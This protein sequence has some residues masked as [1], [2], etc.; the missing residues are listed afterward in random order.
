[1]IKAGERA[2]SFKIKGIYD[3]V[4]E[5][6]SLGVVLR[7]LTKGVDEWDAY[8]DANQEIKVLFKKVC[9]FDINAF[10]GYLTLQSTWFNDY[11]V[12]TDM[13]LL[14]SEVD[15]SAENTIIIR[16]LFYQG[17]DVK[18]RL[19]NENPLT[20]NLFM[21]EHQLM[22]D[23]REAFGTVYGNGELMMY[24]P[25]IYTSYYSTCE[26]FMLLYFVPYV[27]GVGTVGTFVNIMKWISDEEAEYYKRLG[28]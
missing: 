22:G 15:P 27:E 16:N 23:T 2:T 6:D 12:G 19:D 13:R 3:N 14:K 21:D 1:T 28:Y 24:Q 25:T 7:L 5:S 26:Q 17:F 9:P 8:G 4:A 18:V 10:T 20:P 11:M